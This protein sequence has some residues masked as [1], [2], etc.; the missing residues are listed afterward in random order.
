MPDAMAH[1]GAIRGYT[2]PVMRLLLLPLLLA[3]DTRAGEDG[4]DPYDTAEP[5]GT[6]LDTANDADDTGTTEEAVWWRLSGQLQIL[7]G[8]PDREQSTLH[9]TLLTGDLQVLCTAAVAIDGLLEAKALPH[10][11]I[12]TWW[13]LSPGED[14]GGCGEKALPGS[15]FYLGFGAMHPDILPGLQGDPDI[16][17][18]DALNGAYA[19][20]DAGETLLV[21]GAAGPMEVWVS[22]GEPA[23]GPPISDGAW[24]FEAVYTFGYA[25]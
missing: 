6:S 16:A 24:R 9:I 21:F 22:G 2:P 13:L 1:I 8:Q 3:C 12:Y 10:A 17:D 19:S 25:Q 23:T 4:A 18:P 20:L 14:D 11:D 7:K 5:G 15:S